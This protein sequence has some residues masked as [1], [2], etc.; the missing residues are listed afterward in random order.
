M[1]K[2]PPLIHMIVFPNASPPPAVNFPLYLFLPS[3]AC[4]NF[5][6]PAADS[7]ETGDFDVVKDILSLVILSNSHVIRAGYPEVPKSQWGLCLQRSEQFA[8][9]SAEQ[10]PIRRLKEM[11]SVN[12]I[13]SAKLMIM[14]SLKHSL[15]QKQR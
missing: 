12:S 10:G 1:I 11:A 8:S 3:S 4:Q 6:I 9:F 2:I 5:H 14:D 7:L 15:V 13:E